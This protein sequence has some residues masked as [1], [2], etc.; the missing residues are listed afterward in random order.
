MADQT[1]SDHRLYEGMFL[2]SQ[3]HV[4]GDLNAALAAVQQILDR[5]GAEVIALRKWDERRLAY[6]IEGQK[7][8]LY[9]LALFRAA[10][11]QIG[12][13]ERQ[14]N[15]SEQIVRVMFTRADH[16]GETEIQREIDAAQGTR[17]E[18]AL[19]SE[20]ESAAAETPEEQAEDESE[21]GP[22]EEPVATADE[23]S[24]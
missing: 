23:E 22:D 8:G 18:A 11:D 12:P 19:R 5:G 16:M 21:P 6:E 3:Q 10:P 9:V 17:D 4:A 24:A 14:V 1:Q 15:L 20:G 13:M 7:R 2:L